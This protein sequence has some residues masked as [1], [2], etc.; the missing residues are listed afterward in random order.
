MRIGLI[1]P[2]W[3][4]VPPGR[5]GGTEE[6]VDCLARALA[7]R[8]HEVTLFTV[9]ESTCPVPRA[10]HYPTGVVPMGGTLAEAVHTVAAYQALAD[11]DV[12][13]DH[14]TIGPLVASALPHH[15][16]IV[17]TQHATFDANAR[18]VLEVVARRAAI[19]AISHAQRAS[20]PELPVAAVIHHGIDL[21]MYGFGTGGGGY[22][23]FLG[24]MSPDKG[25]HRAIQVARLA[26]RRL[27]VVT[28]M[29]DPDEHAYYEETVRPVL[30]PDVDLL[31]E[32]SAHER[33][34]L[35]Q[36]AD[37]LIN[38]I[39]WPEPF[40]LVMAEAMACGTPVLATPY[41]AAPE[42]VDHGRTGFLVDDEQGMLE[43]LHHLTDIDRATCRATAERRFS[44]GRMAAD[45]EALYHRVSEDRRSRV[46]PDPAPPADHVEPEVNRAG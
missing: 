15:G 21:D 16:P 11:V 2:P 38:P 3:V 20:A 23:L 43:A 4:P 33:I 26:G 28:K 36:G 17:L 5:Y 22:L 14:T 31:V 37:A 25:V 46:L 34:A 42:I 40:G 19:V 35:L 24:R 27:V 41:G 1:A 13:H 12:V 29:R 8:G 32:P 45:Y 10:W 7:A 6:V 9:E 44:M 39:S 30:G 18:V